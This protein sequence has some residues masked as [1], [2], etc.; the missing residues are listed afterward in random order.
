MATLSRLLLPLLLALPVC[1]LAQTQPS[2]DDPVIAKMG[3]MEMRTSQLQHLIEGMPPEARRQLA[4]NPLELDRALRQLMLRNA[5]VAEAREKGWDRRPEVS[6]AMDS[7]RDQALAQAYMNN[8]A[9]PPATFPSEDEVK[10]L[11]E[12]SKSQLTAPA[13]YQLWQIFILAGD[14]DKATAASQ[15][16]LAEIQAK[17]QKAPADFSRLAHEFSDNKD[18]AAKNG[19]LGWIPEDRLVPELRTIVPRLARGEISAPIKANGGWHIIRL[20]DRKP[21]SLRPLAEVHDALVANL[22]LRRAQELERIY[23]DSLAAKTPIT[24]NQIELGRLQGAVK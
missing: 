2:R 11:Y 9:R 3:A 7:A 13:E 23:L 21:A 8:L 16:R 12:A 15:R 22:R 19:E 20:S 17:L 4:S 18:V 6:L 10:A 24:V 1:T 14:D 5:L